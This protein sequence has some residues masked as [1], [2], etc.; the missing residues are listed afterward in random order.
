MAHIDQ[1]VRKHNITEK[2]TCINLH[3]KGIEQH[4]QKVPK[5]LAESMP[6]RLEKVISGIEGHTK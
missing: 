4:K 2:K 6:Q 5:R 3:N 1:N